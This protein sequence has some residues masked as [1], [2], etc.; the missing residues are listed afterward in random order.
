MRYL[1]LHALISFLAAH[2]TACQSNAPQIRAACDDTTGGVY[3][4]KWEL[5]P[6]EEGKVK[7]YSSYDPSFTSPPVLEAEK[8]IGE[9]FAILPKKSDKRKFFKLVFNKNYTSYV[10]ER[11]I[12]TER[13]MN[14]RDLGGYNKGKQKQIQWAKLYRS[15][16][17]AHL[18]KADRITLDSLGI[19]TIIDLR[20]DVLRKRSPSVYRPDQTLALN[21]S[22]L[23]IDSIRSKI[24]EGK[25]LKGDVLIALQDL[26][27][28]II[29]QD[30]AA[31][32]QALHLL[33][34]ASV[35]PV[36]LHCNF[37]KDQTGIL[38]ILILEALGIEREQIFNDYMLS[39]QHIN[40]SKILS[41]VDDLP[42]EAEEPLI[43]L[44]SVNERMFRFVYQII[45]KEYGS[46]QTYLQKVLHFTESDQEQ[47]RNTLLYPE[48]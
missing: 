38:S 43:T 47:L 15:A 18:S 39:N 5:F 19:K 41:H 35:Y 14:L 12:T 33:T 7:I 21:L 8:C 40:F 16:N 32:S 34:Q 23:S 44:L 27:A 42:L 22:K 11:N 48:Q 6:R 36:L 37:G 1:A 4:L 31:L 17:I 9:D 3:T 29:K 28:Q 30:T 25:M 2:F 26:Y 13:I 45:D 24:V 10:A 46:M 20:A